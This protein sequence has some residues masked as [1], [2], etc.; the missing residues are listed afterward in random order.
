[1][2]PRTRQLL[3]AFDPVI[4]EKLLESSPESEEFPEIPDNLFNKDDDIVLDLAE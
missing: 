3:E 2:Q 1:M 4:K